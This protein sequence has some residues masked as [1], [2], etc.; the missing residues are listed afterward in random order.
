MKK[1]LY[2]DA[3]QQYGP[4]DQ[5][6]ATHRVTTYPNSFMA[7]EMRDGRVARQ[8][9]LQECQKIATRVIHWYALH[10]I[11]ARHFLS[12]ESAGCPNN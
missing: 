4:C 10:A 11:E 8:L 6:V 1:H 7:C 12:P 5:K 3:D 2:V 9:T